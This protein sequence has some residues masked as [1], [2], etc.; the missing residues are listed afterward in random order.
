MTSPDG[1]SESLSSFLISRL[2]LEKFVDLFSLC[3]HDLSSCCLEGV[4]PSILG[5]TTLGYNKFIITC[6]LVNSIAKKRPQRFALQ[7]W[8]LRIASNQR[9][10]DIFAAAKNESVMSQKGCGRE[11]Y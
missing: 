3:Y 9:L 1:V 7:Q 5:T 6:V 4:F 8:F 10:V 11:S 2:I